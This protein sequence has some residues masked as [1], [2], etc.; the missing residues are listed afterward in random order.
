MTLGLFG[1]GEEFEN[2]FGTIEWIAGQ[3]G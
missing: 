2:R 1:G 3:L